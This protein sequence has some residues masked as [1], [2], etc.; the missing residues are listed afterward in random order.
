M[1]F[2]MPIHLEMDVEESGAEVA[3]RRLE[4]SRFLTDTYQFIQE[5]VLPP[6][7]WPT[8]ETVLERYWA[9]RKARGTED[10]DFL[11]LAACLAA[12]GNAARAIPVAASWSLYLLAGRIFDDLADREGG[13]R[14]LFAGSAAPTP[15]SACM[16]AVATAA[17]TL[18]HLDD[19]EVCRQVSMAFSHSLALAIKS[20]NVQPELDRLSVEAYFEAI[21]AKTGLVFAVGAWAGGRAGVASPDP[22][23][24]ET[25]HTYGL[26]LGMMT[27]IL[28]DC[29][30]LKADLANQVWTLP[31]IYGLRQ[32]THALNSSLK[33]L[34]YHQQEVTLTWIE[35]VADILAQMEAVAWSLR[36]A[37][38]HRQ[39]ALAAVI[40]IPYRQDLL[41]HYVTP[42]NK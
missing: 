24:L 31:L 38:V 37:E 33:K 14:A 30:D 1:T 12:G 39:K 40:T 18:N 10:I 34:L 32:T 5:E 29:L 26:H 21:A 11:P 27:Q 2:N 3:S 41:Q 6:F 7:N 35:D 8:F 20:E 16:F 15:L 25:L 28:D 19:A 23:V 9:K 13:E 17:A 4:I 22:D 42:Q 36:L